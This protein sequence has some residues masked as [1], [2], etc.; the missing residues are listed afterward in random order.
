MTSSLVE[1]PIVIAH[2]GVPGQRLE[3]TR[4]SYLLGVEQGAD[5]IEPDV[6]ATKD[7]VLVVRHENEI[8]GT[9]D[10]AEHPEF[11]HLQATKFVDGVPLNGWFTEDFTLA[12]LKTLRCRERLP[13]LRPQNL[14]L[15]GTEQIMTFDEVLDLAVGKSVGVYVETKHPTY[16]RTIGLDLNDLLI[17]NLTRRNL[18]HRGANVI[19]Q[20]METAN[21]KA[22]RSRTDLPLIQLLDRTGAPYDLV[23]TY[24][25]RDYAA[26]TTSAELAK[27]AEYADGIGPNK[28]LVI[29]RDKNHRL[30]GETGLVR[31]A[32]AVG[33]LVHI[34]TM[35][36]ENNF[37][38][39]DFKSGGDKSAH[40]DGTAEF[41]AFYRAGVD[42]V[43]ADYTET[44]VRARAV[45]LSAAGRTSDQ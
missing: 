32:H 34:W 18:N 10:V 7:G 36:N 30:T 1:T 14:A 38:P 35:R 24:D 23:A 15:G 17:E 3:H 41:L 43:F 40:G 27:I 44:A 21:L 19:I 37:L 9:T 33:L 29:G 28:S 5:F 8:S 11:A 22:L 45:H 39:V 42:G 31:D 16:F 25:Y 13:Q 20:S 4:A 26:L 6:V 2:R 12:E